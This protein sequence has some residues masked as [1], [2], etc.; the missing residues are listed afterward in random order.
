MYYSHGWKA[1][2]DGNEVPILR[3]DYA[4][5]GLQIPK[6]NH[7]IEF[8]FNPKV[9]KKGSTIALASS[10]LL[11]LIVLGSIFMGIKRKRE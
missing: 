10:I 4:L 8:T 9:I 3:V 5:R 6:G 1:T 7:I 2:I 11:G